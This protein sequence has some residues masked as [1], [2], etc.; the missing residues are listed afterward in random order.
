MTDTQYCLGCSQEKPTSEF[1]I[2]WG[3]RR[4]NYCKVCSKDL[5]GWEE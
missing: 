4:S 5:E 3:G 1:P 2:T